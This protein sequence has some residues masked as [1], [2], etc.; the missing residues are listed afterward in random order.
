M[1]NFGGTPGTAWK[2]DTAKV[3]W[4]FRCSFKN[5]CGLCCQFANRVGNYWPIPMHFG[6][7]CLQEAVRPGATAAPFVDF[8]EEIAALDEAQQARVIGRSNWA[9]VR[10]GAVKWED[11]VTRSRVRDFR[12][13]VA[14][15]NLTAA[16]LIKSGVSRREA[17]RAHGAVHTAAH[18]RLDGERAALVQALRGHGLPDARAIEEA[19]RLMG[20]SRLAI[21][22][23]P[24]LPQLPPRSTRPPG[25]AAPPSAP[26][27]SAPP[28]PTPPKPASLPAPPVPASPAPATTT[29][30]AIDRAVAY[31]TSLGVRIIAAGHAELAA[32]LGKDRVRGVPAAY[33]WTDRTIRINERQVMW[34]RPAEEMAQMFANRWFSTGDPEH[35]IVHEVGHA[36]HHRAVGDD[37]FKL[38]RA[39]KFGRAELALLGGKV[40]AYGRTSPVEFVAEVFA[41]LVVGRTYPDDGIV[42]RIYRKYGGPD[43]P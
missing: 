41:S 11:V 26:P 35:I 12:D 24:M 1:K 28:P 16:D 14:M 17:D 30:P 13:V 38:V 19:G 40:S 20:E 36:L 3:S 42:M 27:P 21:R 6:C 39:A 15:K 7:N 34:D 23:G 37:R 8:M 10:S 29:R 22:R 33:R 5:S 32:G 18:R 43:P 2:N 4:Q 31:A 9:L 25:P